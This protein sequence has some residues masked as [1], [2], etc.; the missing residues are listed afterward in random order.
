[1]HAKGF[2]N[3]T[4][5]NFPKDRYRLMDHNKA[6]HTSKGP[7]S[8]IAPQTIN[9]SHLPATTL[10]YKSRDHKEDQRSIAPILKN[11]VIGL[12]SLSKSDNQHKQFF[13]LL[14]RSQFRLPT[15][16]KPSAFSSKLPL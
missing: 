5:I 12:V 1:M 6:L 9:Q 8:D 3:Q 2:D 10:S 11:T 7:I 4:M 14:Q 15:L 13:Y 16:V